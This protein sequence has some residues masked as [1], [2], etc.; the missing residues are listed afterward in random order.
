MGN[1]ISLAAYIK[2]LILWMTFNSVVK[3]ST[4]KFQAYSSVVWYFT[5]TIHCNIHYNHLSSHIN[6]KYTSE[7]A[8]TR[9]TTVTWMNEE[10]LK[11][12][13][14]LSCRMDKSYQRTLFL[15]SWCLPGIILLSLSFSLFGS[16]NSIL[17]WC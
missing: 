6:V 16:A 12:H 17:T 11:W 8:S 5:S 1:N 10:V 9:H 4:S 2:R 7:Q 14:M 15:T 3:I 13:A